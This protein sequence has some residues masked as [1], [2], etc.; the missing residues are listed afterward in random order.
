MSLKTTSSISNFQK[1]PPNFLQMKRVLKHLRETRIGGS[2]MR[3]GSMIIFCKNEEAWRGRILDMGT[4]RN[5]KTFYF[6]ENAVSD[7]GKV[8]SFDIE[9]KDIIKSITDLEIE[10]GFYG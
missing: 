1:K 8:Q 7:N 3:I 9:G 5:G 10:Y 2:S 6:V 4:L